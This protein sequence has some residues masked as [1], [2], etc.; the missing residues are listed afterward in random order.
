VSSLAD[1]HVFNALVLCSG[2][3][4]RRGRVGLPTGPP[5][6]DGELPDGSHGPSDRQGPGGGAAQTQ[7]ALG[8][9][10]GEKR[11]RKFR[12]TGKKPAR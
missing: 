11:I 7:R 5:E 3:V 10:R 8:R 2:D 4:R 9:V 1:A 6:R 12:S